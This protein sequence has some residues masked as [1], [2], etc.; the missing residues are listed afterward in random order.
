MTI[1]LISIIVPVYN[2]EK[3]LNRCVD[4][5]TAQTFTDWECLLIDDGSTDESPNIC[6]E[7]ARRDHRIRVFHKKNGGVAS[8]RQYGM[9]KSKG[10]Y[11][12]HMDAD[13]WADAPMLE[14]MY[15]WARKSNAELVIADFYIYQEF[16]DRLICHN[17]DSISSEKV[18]KMILREKMMGSLWNKLIR[19]ESYLQ[20]GAKFVEKIDYCEDVL[21]LMQ[22]LSHPIRISFLH[23][24][25]YHY[26]KMN[27]NS[28]T[29][30]Y[31]KETFETRLNFLKKLK[32]ILN[33]DDFGQEIK[34]AEFCVKMEALYRG[35]INRKN[36]GVILPS[37]V[38]TILRSN[39]NWKRKLLYILFSYRLF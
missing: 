20:Y 26:N 31:T 17:I 21:I 34:D 33:V 13:D 14:G 2:A 1:P 7:Y 30:R 35:Y 3:Y 25:F 19:R 28:I 36:F 10:D 11:I 37:S 6:D 27:D 32:E 23:E 5:I 29:T 4:S 39:C 22:L 9:E 16:K 12:I 24:A 8:A 18:C 38:K 15:K